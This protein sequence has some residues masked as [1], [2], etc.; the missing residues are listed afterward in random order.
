[1]PLNLYLIHGEDEVRI[2]D[3]RKRIVE[4]LL[5]EEYQAENLC[6]IEP[7]G[8]RPLDLKSCAM[9]I[10]NELGT[11]SF[12]EEARRVVI[13]SNLQDFCTAREKGGVAGKYH[14]VHL[15]N[16]EVEGGITPGNSYP[17]F[18][19]DFGRIG[20][21]ICYDVHYA[22]TARALAAQGAEIIFLPIEGGRSP[23]PSVR[24]IEN[25]VYL[26]TCG[27]KI[28]SAIYDRLG[29]ILGEAKER[30]GVAYV[31]IDLNEQKTKRG[32]G[33][34]QHRFYR[35]LRNDIPIKGLRK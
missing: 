8:N 25:D 10:V 34:M 15:P 27:Y 29:N 5:P 4:N 19:T 17:V 26:V 13:V 35:E 31:D 30:P 14:K 21:M 33:N 32:W 11:L 23:I 6:E 12:F 28:S 9:D 22:E 1:M 24:T 16:Q 20:M 3:E 7:I 18:D 2:L